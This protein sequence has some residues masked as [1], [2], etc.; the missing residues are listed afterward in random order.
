MIFPITYTR[1]LA[2]G[3]ALDNEGQIDLLSGTELT[4]EGIMGGIND[5]DAETQFTIVHNALR[6]SNNP[7]LGLQWGND[8]HIA[9]HG[10]LGQLIA[11][12]PTV[13]HA[14]K[15]IERFHGIRGDFASI[16]G[17][18]V[19]QSFVMN[20]HLRM[21]L[22]KVGLFFLEAL[23]AV[24][25]RNFELIAGLKQKG[26]RVEL[27][28]D[29]PLHAALYEKHLSL[30]CQ[31]G[32]KET[33]IVTPLAL[34]NL[35]NPMGDIGAYENLLKQCEYFSESQVQ[36]KN[37]TQRVCELLRH[38]PG[39]IW[40]LSDV[41]GHFHVSSRTLTRY[42]T[43]EGSSYQV[44]LDSELGALAKRYLESL[45]YTVESIAQM[46]GYKDVSSFRRAFKRWFSVSPSNY[47][48][49]I[50]NRTQ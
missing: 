33:S 24:F 32:A 47:M 17:K 23:L 31:F 8:L 49:Q 34:T 14:W 27:G 45:Q 4:P 2:L 41:A 39:H 48:V 16:N 21:P 30:P 1:M 42:L 25:V 44:L 35:L 18:V 10:L 9:S 13:R 5:V 22:D 12:S 7:G 29:A 38:N 46:L 19:D 50:R 20:F 11:S 37:W 28:Y 3:M 26:V 40:T 15:G 36:L 43:E 6:I